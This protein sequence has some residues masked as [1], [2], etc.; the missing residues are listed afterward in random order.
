MR[1][2]W[3]AVRL[4]AHVSQLDGLLACKRAV[5][6]GRS[7]CASTWK[8]TSANPNAS[9]IRVWQPSEELP[10]SGLAPTLQKGTKQAEPDQL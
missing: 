7:V 4:S 3:S 9:A 2:D 1:T 6:I 10:G 8:N 5:A